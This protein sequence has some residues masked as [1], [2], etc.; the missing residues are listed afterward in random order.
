MKDHEI[1]K[2]VQN[3]INRR[4]SGLQDNPNLAWQVMNQQEGEQIVMKKKLSFTLVFALCAL[5]VM[6]VALAVSLS[7]SPRYDA[8]K[9][10]NEA[11]STTYGIEDKMLTVFHRQ[12]TQNPDGSSTITYRS[13]EGIEQLGLYTVEVKDGKAKAT[14]SLEGKETSGGLKAEAWGREQLQLMVEDYEAVMSFLHQQAPEQ[15]QPAT[16]PSMTEEDY[17]KAAA[18]TKSKV[19]AAAK[20]TRQEAF[21]LGILALQSEKGLTQEQ[22]KKLIAYEEDDTY[23]YQERPLLSI[24]YH[25]SQGAQWAEKDGI[26][27]VEINMETGEVEDLIYDS[28]LAAN[29]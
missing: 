3:T 29:G 1:K 12:T 2:N 18:E 21:D 6:G 8:V 23:A 27:V 26:Y 11:L 20:I 14:W 25:L 24:Y 28:G 16:T 5:L 22:V 17:K 9:L 13:V 10:A 7:F 4:L 19:L 15:R